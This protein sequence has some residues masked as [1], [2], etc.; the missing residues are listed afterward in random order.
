[1]NPVIGEQINAV[2]SHHQPNL[3][4]MINLGIL[5][6]KTGIP[7]RAL[8]Q[9]SVISIAKIDGNKPEVDLE[10]TREKI[11]GIRIIKNQPNGSR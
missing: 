1:M 4:I 2:L 8:D 5:V 7:G 6:M 9:A 10:I 3:E 11:D